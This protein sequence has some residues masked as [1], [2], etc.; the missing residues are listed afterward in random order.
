MTE[1]KIIPSRSQRDVDTR[2]M[3]AEIADAPDLASIIDPDDLR[4]PHGEVERPEDERMMRRIALALL[5]ARFTEDI[6]GG[7]IR[8]VKRALDSAGIPLAMY[9]QAVQN[10]RFQAIQ[11]EIHRCYVLAPR[12]SSVMLALSKRA[13]TGE[14]AAVKDFMKYLHNQDEDT[15][16]AIRKLQ[17]QGGKDNLIR[18]IEDIVRRSDQ[19]KRDLDTQI[20]ADAERAE[21]VTRMGEFD[22]LEVAEHKVDHQTLYGKGDEKG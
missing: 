9:E 5:E 21:A 6:E 14:S 16:S 10:E 2:Q 1:A 20:D 22:A 12:A 4:A 7:D 11:D 15:L 8:V 19:I 17:A 13:A 3:L 18:L